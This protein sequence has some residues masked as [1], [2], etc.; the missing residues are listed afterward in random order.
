MAYIQSELKSSKNETLETDDVRSGRR[1]RYMPWIL[2]I[3]TIAATLVLFFI[4]AGFA[5]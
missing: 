4:F 5:V 3:S 2:G 1:V